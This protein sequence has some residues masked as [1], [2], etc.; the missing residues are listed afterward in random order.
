MVLQDLKDDTDLSVPKVFAVNNSSG[1]SLEINGLDFFLDNEI[2][3]VNRW[4]QTVFGPKVYKNN[5]P[6]KSWDGRKNGKPLPS[7]AYYYFIRYK[8]KD[9][10]KVKKGIIYLVEG[11]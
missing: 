4:G 6:E 8:N 3:I 5:A 9:V 2:T 1:S 11:L 7:G 10:L